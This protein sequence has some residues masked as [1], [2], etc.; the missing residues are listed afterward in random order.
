M[1]L[2]GVLGQGV[3][4]LGIDERLISRDDSEVT[5]VG[6]AVAQLPDIFL[7]GVGED[8]LANDGKLFPV[9]GLEGVEL[10]NADLFHAKDRTIIDSPVNEGLE[11]VLVLHDELVVDGLPQLPV[12]IAQVRAVS[13]ILSA[14]ALFDVLRCVAELGDE[15]PRVSPSQESGLH[16]DLVELIGREGR[17]GT[18]AVNQATDGIKRSGNLPSNGISDVLAVV[19]VDSLEVELLLVNKPVPAVDKE[20]ER[21]GGPADEGV[22]AAALPFAKTGE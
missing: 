16:D 13:T 19:E 22:V 7:R 1:I 12:I 15:E 3:E 9:D 20:G 8:L 5:F 14:I 10:G 11:Q 6:E 18:L 17:L 4:G 2:A 21:R